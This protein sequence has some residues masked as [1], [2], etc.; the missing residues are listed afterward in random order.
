[1]ILGPAR[2]KV[3]NGCGCG[4]S[5]SPSTAFPQLTDHM[6]RARLPADNYY[7][8]PLLR[9]LE[10]QLLLAYRHCVSSNLLVLKLCNTRNL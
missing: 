7:S 10:K 2:A 1:V 9:N 3:N 8:T 5:A 6:I 4:A